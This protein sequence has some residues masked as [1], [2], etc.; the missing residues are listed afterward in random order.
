MNPNLFKGNPNLE[1]I[2]FEHNSLKNIDGNI[3]DPVKK[4][5][6]LSLSRNYLTEFPIDQFPK[7]DKLEKLHIFSNDLT[8]LD[9]QTLLEKFPILQQITMH[10]FRFRRTAGPVV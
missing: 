4:L 9:E 7:L 3:F 1:A 2:F 6:F 10:N 5:K 8:D